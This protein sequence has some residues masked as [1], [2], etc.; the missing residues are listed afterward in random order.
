[1]IGC[2][3]CG[4]I[5]E[6]VATRWLCPACKFKANCC[7][8]EPQ[9]IKAYGGVGSRGDRLPDRCPSEAVDNER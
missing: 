5:F 7:D 9:P 6:P 4:H 8:G 3:S 1:M 2:D